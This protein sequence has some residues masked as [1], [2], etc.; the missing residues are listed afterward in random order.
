MNNDELLLSIDRI[1]AMMIDVATG[2]RPIN[3]V[4]DGYRALYAR[5][6]ASLG[7]KGIPN[8]LPYGDLW[9]WYGRWKNGDMPTYQSRREFVNRFIEPLLSVIRTGHAEPYLPTGW[10]RVDRVAGELRDRLASA[11][12]E[13]QFQAVGLFGREVLISVAQAVFVPERHPTE[14]GV[15]PSD[16]DAN[17][18][19]SAYFATELQ[20]GSN[21]EIRSHARS[22]LKPAVA[23]QH[24]R[25]A[26]FR[27]AAMCVEAT[28]AVVNLV[29]ILSGRR[30]PVP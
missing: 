23:L 15:P 29:A 19:L 22:A 26:S 13:E 7:R 20:G 30:D 12:T 11:S 5:V 8:T 9:E 3:D 21:E 28:T 14:D 2:G 27:D 1:R 18:M 4:N 10:T 24:R 6:A 17:R 25:T 16:T